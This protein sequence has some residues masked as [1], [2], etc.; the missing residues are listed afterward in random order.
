[1]HTDNQH[2][3]LMDRAPGVVKVVDL[4]YLCLSVFIGGK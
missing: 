4:P 1:M 2:D 3:L